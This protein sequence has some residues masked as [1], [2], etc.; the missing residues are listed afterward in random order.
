MIRVKK[1]QRE[2]NLKGLYIYIEA[3]KRRIKKITVEKS[4]IGSFVW[5]GHSCPR[6]LVTG[7]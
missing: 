4:R 3:K 7:K 5:R 1:M 2:I 6:N